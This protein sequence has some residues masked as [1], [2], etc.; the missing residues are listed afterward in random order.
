MLFAYIH[1]EI[2]PNIEKK[3]IKD[4]F[5]MLKKSENWLFSIDWSIN[6][7]N[8][9][10]KNTEHSLSLIIGNPVTSKNDEQIFS[11]IE[12]H[13]YQREHLEKYLSG[14]YCFLK[15]S[16]E[17]RNIHIERTTYSNF[18]LF[19]YIGDKVAIVSDNFVELSKWIRIEVNSNLIPE[20]LLYKEI[21]GPETLARNV[22]RLMPREKLIIKGQKIICSSKLKVPEINNSITKTDLID[23]VRNDLVSTITYDRKRYGKIT[24]SLSGGLDSSLTQHLASKVSADNV[25]DVYSISLQI[26]NYPERNEDNYALSA[27]KSFNCIPNL[28]KIFEKDVNPLVN[29]AIFESG[30]PLPHLQSAWFSKMALEISKKYKFCYSSEGA[31]SLFGSEYMLHLYK[32]SLFKKT[33]LYK[34]SVINILKRISL[35]FPSNRLSPFLNTIINEGDMLSSHEIL[36]QSGYITDW[37]A[38]TKVTG[39]DILQNTLDRRRNLFHSYLPSQSPL[40]TKFSI[41]RVISSVAPTLPKWNR[42]MSSKNVTFLYPFANSSIFNMVMTSPEKTRFNLFKTKPVVRELLKGIPEEIIN[43]PK[44]SFGVPLNYFI[45]SEKILGHLWN[46]ETFPE[47]H[48]ITKKMDL[49]D[50]NDHVLWAILGLKM[51]HNHFCMNNGRG[52]VK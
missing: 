13:D 27:S 35:N 7:Q 48:A 3:S 39:P 38:I 29:E 4:S 12:K 5:S 52:Y 26:K 20:F 37:D 33:I 43:R 10:V 23:G 17:K 9:I 21:I 6:D 11:D 51:W 24:N 8:Y 46:T 28:V 22:F 18:D 47:L 32:L 30:Y 31:D 1:R 40:S 36:N 34:K 49:Q 2:L 45:R 25:K 44:K 16:K 19:Y 41:A 14:Y 15:F 42:I 50:S